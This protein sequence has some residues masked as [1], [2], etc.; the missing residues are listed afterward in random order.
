M[1]PQPGFSM[2]LVSGNPWP[3]HTMAM[4]P[5]GCGG[6]RKYSITGVSSADL[7]AF[8]FIEAVVHE[9]NCPGSSFSAVTVS[10]KYS[11]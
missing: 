4:A 1:D 6:K 11:R 3:I 7:P 9:G 10:L 5:M 8:G 2:R